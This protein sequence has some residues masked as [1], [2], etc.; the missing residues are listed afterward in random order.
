MSLLLPRLVETLEYMFF[1][2]SIFNIEGTYAKYLMD[3][4]GGHPIT[5]IH[6]GQSWIIGGPSPELQAIQKRVIARFQNWTFLAKRVMQS[7]FPSFGIMTNLARATCLHPKI[8][9]YKFVSVCRP[10]RKTRMPECNHTAL[11]A[12]S[13]VW[14]EWNADPWHKRVT[15]NLRVS[16]QASQ[17]DG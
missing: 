13:G 1:K 2:D 6:R 16:G 15:S 5:L 14:K 7:E 8:L 11:Q 3:T 4:L 17:R 9:G 12:L 10:L